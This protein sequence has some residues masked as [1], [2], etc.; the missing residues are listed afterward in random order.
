[1]VEILPA[2]AFLHSSGLIYC[3]FKPD[4]IIQQGDAIKL[5]DLGG[6]RRADDTT[7]AIYGTV[8]YQAPE[9]PKVGPSIAGDIY[10]R[11]HAR[12][13]RDGAARLPVNLR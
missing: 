13:A 2:F 10:T 3:D 6:V 4:N 1:M 7:S 8:G 11:P 9:V 5:I 12:D